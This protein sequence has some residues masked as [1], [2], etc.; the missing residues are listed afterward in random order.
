MGSVK[1]KHLFRRPKRPE[2]PMVPKSKNKKEKKKHKH[3]HKRKHHSHDTSSNQNSQ[4]SQNSQNPSNIDNTTPPNTDNINALYRY[5][6]N[7]GPAGVVPFAVVPPGYNPTQI[8]HAYGLNE[9]FIGKTSTLL[10]GTGQTIAIINAYTDPK[11]SSDFVTF[12]NAFGLPS[13]NK[14]VVHPMATGIASNSS[15]GVEQSL[16]VQWSHALA[17]GATI[18]LIQAKSNSI[19]DLLAAVD[20]ASTTSASVISMSWGANEFTGE[21]ALGSHFT[22]ANK[23]YIASSGDSGGLVIWPA[24]AQTVMGIGGTTLNLNSSGARISETAWS[25]SGGGVST[26]IPLPTYQKSYGLTV[27]RNTPDVSFDANPSTGLAVYDSFGYSGWLEV[28]GTS[29]GA[30]CWAAIIA[31]A[32]QGR[33]LVKKAALTNSTFL[34][35]LYNT[36]GKSP[37]YALDFYDITTGKAGNNSAKVGYDFVTGL[38]SPRVNS[39]TSGI[40]PALINS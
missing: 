20:Y 25:G 32:N 37:N 5:V 6:I 33:A 15:W 23:V 7:A 3:H 27:R 35:Y 12:S 29:V 38:G 31:L 9:L 34:N 40:V 10:D 36:A 39:N 22:K 11:I 30:P 13:T 26:Q 1:H 8:K 28:G 24:A 16:D 17:P 19:T 14:L 18:L 21:N 4:N 2:M